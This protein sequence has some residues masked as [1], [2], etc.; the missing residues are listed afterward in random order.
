MYGFR[1]NNF[2]TPGAPACNK[3]DA[4]IDDKLGYLNAGK[5]ALP[6]SAKTKLVT[7]DIFIQCQCSYPDF[8]ASSGGKVVVI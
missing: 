7:R 3:K 6:L 2:A 4:N 1:M 5:I 8:H